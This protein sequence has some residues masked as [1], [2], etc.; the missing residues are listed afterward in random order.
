MSLL[1]LPLIS[2]GITDTRFVVVEV[3]SMPARKCPVLIESH[4]CRAPSGLS[5]STSAQPFEISI[6]LRELGWKAY[7]VQFDSSATAWIAKVIDW[8]VAV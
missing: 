4:K 1:L 6:A 8:G 2:L 5:V 7:R 3:V